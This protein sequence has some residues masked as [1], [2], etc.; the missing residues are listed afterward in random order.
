MFLERFQPEPAA[1]WN[2]RR[3]LRHLIRDSHQ[4]NQAIRVVSY[5]DDNPAL[6]VGPQ[7]ALAAA[8]CGIAAELVPGREDALLPLR[9]AWAKHDK[10]GYLEPRDS[11]VAVEHESQW[12]GWSTKD[13]CVR[14][15]P[16]QIAVSI[17]TVERSHPSLPSFAGTSVLAISA[18]AA[19]ADEL[20]RVAL[21]ATDSG[22]AIDG[23][24]LV[25]PEPW[26]RG[27][28]VVVRPDYNGKAQQM[29]S[30][31]GEGATMAGRV[32]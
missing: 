4:L 3:A 17:H 13:S 25:N 28:A 26:D 19:V 30:D 15:R 22:G 18:G 31:L 32:T 21:A 2:L 6:S 23:I 12:G 20:A 27:T 16:N 14:P 10:S 24:F 1:R 7:L 5:A 8:D 29:R 9:A 11:P